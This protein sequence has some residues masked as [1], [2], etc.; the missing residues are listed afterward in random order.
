MTPGEQWR[1]RALL[2]ARLTSAAAVLI[3]AAI[4]FALV[5]LRVLRHGPLAGIDGRV[6]RKLAVAASQS[7]R[8]ARVAELVTDFGHWTVLGTVALCVAVC[9]VVVRRWRDLAFLL[10]TVVVGFAVAALLKLVVSQARSAFV[11][12]VAS[13]LDKSFPSGHAMNSAFVYGAL[14]LLVFPRLRPVQRWAAVMAT[15]AVVVGI[16]AS[17]VA[18]GYHYIS[19]V[20]AGAAFGVA[21][22][23][24]AAWAFSSWR[25]DV[26]P[27]SEA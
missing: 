1:A 14:L 13:G 8:A 4:P 23:G 10:T 20:V 15:V 16:S 24:A 11:E 19:D 7:P 2:A 22:L 25:R 3:V 9:L 18:I 6:A 12:P 17:R 21:W 26:A 5:L 27:P